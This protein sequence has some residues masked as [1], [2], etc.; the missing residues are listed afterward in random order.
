MVFALRKPD[1]SERR[2]AS[3]LP[4]TG[5]FPLRTPQ[6]ALMSRLPLRV[7]LGMIPD[8]MDPRTG[9]FNPNLYPR[10]DQVIQGWA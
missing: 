9:P 10:W 3:A 6:V 4:K 5:V 1:R 7:R 2:M 8:C